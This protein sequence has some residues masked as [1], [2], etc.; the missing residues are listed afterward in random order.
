MRK[1]IAVMFATIGSILLILCILFTAL[2]FT[3][4]DRRFIEY[5]Y[6]R[7]SLSRSLGVSNP[8]LVRAC[9]RLIDYMEGK[10]D[11]IEVLVTVN[12]EEMPMFEEAQE[13]SHMKDVRLLYQTFRSY[14]DYGVLVALVCCLLAA[15]LHFRTA[16]HTLASGYAYGA[17]VI[18]LFVGFLGT[19]ALLDFSSFWTFFHQMLFWNEDWLFDASTSRMINMLPERFFSDMIGR[20][21]IFAGAG[22]AALLA[23]SI[24]ILASLRKKRLLAREKAISAR[25]SRR[26]AQQADG[27]EAQES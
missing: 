4:N 13:I 11:S 9:S 24:C 25:R 19:W 6:S 7:L 23:A 10:V 27:S 12:G 22:F 17:F 16:L 26:A 2:Q 14:R 1:R 3:M 18:A 5:E 21:M 20:M 15:V 8:D